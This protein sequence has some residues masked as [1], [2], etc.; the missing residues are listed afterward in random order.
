LSRKDWLIPVKV[1]NPTIQGVRK[2]PLKPPCET[3]MET[4][5]Y[6]SNPGV[7]KTSVFLTFKNRHETQLSLLWNIGKGRAED[8]CDEGNEVFALS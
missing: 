6:L 3:P 4:G 7:H 5:L 2:T 1:H 8:K